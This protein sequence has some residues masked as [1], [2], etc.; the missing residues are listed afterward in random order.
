M[1]FI[2]Y[3]CNDYAHL[4]HWWK[5]LMRI[6]SVSFVNCFIS[7]NM[8]FVALK[9]MLFLGFNSWGS[10]KYLNKLVQ[11]FVFMKYTHESYSREVSHIIESTM[12]KVREGN[13]CNNRLRINSQSLRKAG[14]A[15][16]YSIPGNKLMQNKG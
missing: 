5:Y 15:R 3:V 16:P 14:V 10:M 6:I 11:R 13:W 2:R 7:M 12:Y 1:S 8:F 4:V 9:N